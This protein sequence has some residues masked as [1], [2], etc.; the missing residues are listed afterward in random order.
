VVPALHFTGCPT[1]SE[2]MAVD[3]ALG[4]LNAADQAAFEEHLLTCQSCRDEVEFAD[5]YARSMAG[6]ARQLRNGGE[7]E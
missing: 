4:L 2:E 6:A 3:Y 5:V 1:D 7:P